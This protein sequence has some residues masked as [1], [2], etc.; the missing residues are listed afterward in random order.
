MLFDGASSGGGT[1]LFEDGVVSEV[2]PPV[3][4]DE[5]SPDGSILGPPARGHVF[6]CRPWD[7]GELRIL[8]RAD[9]S[10]VLAARLEAATRALWNHIRR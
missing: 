3:N 5:P 8:L 7:D 2:G 1:D 9:G 4:I 10:A 6:R